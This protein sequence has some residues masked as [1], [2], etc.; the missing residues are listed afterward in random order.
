M[1]IWVVFDSRYKLEQVRS[2]WNKLEGAKEKKK[3]V[4][5]MVHV[6][7]LDDPGSYVLPAD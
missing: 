7:R 5:D 3:K 4:L 6:L 2:S 1:L